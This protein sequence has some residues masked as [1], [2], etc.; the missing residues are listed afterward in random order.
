MNDDNEEK[1]IKEQELRDIY[2]DPL[3]GYRPAEKLFRKAKENGLKKI[4]RKD[5]NSWLKSQETYTRC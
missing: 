4:S 1:I 3:E 5:V 2:Y